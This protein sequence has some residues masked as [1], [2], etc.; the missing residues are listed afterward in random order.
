MR[1][2]ATQARAA[3]QGVPALLVQLGLVVWLEVL[4]RLDAQVLEA[5]LEVLRARHVGAG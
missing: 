2:R 1:T 4:E 3:V 5:S